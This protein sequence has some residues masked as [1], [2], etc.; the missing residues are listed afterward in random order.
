MERK[1]N[2][3]IAESTAAFENLMN[4]IAPKVTL[5]KN[6][7][8]GKGLEFDGYRQF[9]QDEDA[10]NIDWKASLRSG[11][12][13]AKKYI[14][15]RDLNF[16]FVFDMGE[17]MVFGSQEKLKC[18]IAV[19]LV[20]AFSSVILNSGDRVGFMLYNK[21]IF[22]VAVPKNGTLQHDVFVH[23]ITV[24]ENYQGS[25][26]FSNILKELEKTLS[27]INNIIVLVSDFIKIKEEDR[28]ILEWL[29]NLFET[30]AISIKDPLDS[31]FP[32]IEGEIVI[33][34]PETG[35]KKMINPK[36]VKKI[37]EQNAEEN[38]RFVKK[39]FKDSNIDF[40]DLY[41]NDDFIFELARFLKERATIN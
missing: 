12:Q 11:T 13:L 21:N 1:L 18:E 32:E 10:S 25:T 24:P 30:I 39:M 22:R 41:T 29:G 38:I 14:E 6:L 17:N 5:Y 37:Y 2:V 8:R 35:E 16:M 28:F 27:P 3:D 9:G 19:E 4:E 40:L 26:S 7:F 23:E 34:D 31:F 36:I 15:E 33:E 20:A